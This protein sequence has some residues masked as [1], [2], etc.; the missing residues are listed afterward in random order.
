MKDEILKKTGKIEKKKTSAQKDL[1]NVQTGRKT[2]KTMFKNANDASSMQ[3]KM[4]NVSNF[5][6]KLFSF[7]ILFY[8]N[9][10][11]KRN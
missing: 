10:D 2:V 1:D 9:L 4:E 3:N 8:F 7:K 11:R 6:Q 5:T